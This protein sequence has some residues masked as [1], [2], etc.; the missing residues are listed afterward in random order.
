MIS[1]PKWNKGKKQRKIDTSF[2]K[3]LDTNSR[4]TYSN[5]ESKWMVPRAKKAAKNGIF[6]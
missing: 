4:M 6:F 3:S 2:Q 1:V 5:A